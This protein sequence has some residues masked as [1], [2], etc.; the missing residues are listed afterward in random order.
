MST[1]TIRTGALT[2]GASCSTHP[3]ESAYDTVSVVRP[4]ANNTTF[5]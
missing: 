3:G 2:F 5:N 4:G 1:S